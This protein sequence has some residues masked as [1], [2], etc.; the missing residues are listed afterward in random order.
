MDFLAIDRAQKNVGD[1]KKMI[2]QRFSL[3]EWLSSSFGDKKYD[4]RDHG[5]SYGK[6]DHDPDPPDGTS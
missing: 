5:G 2:L 3:R 1:I 6:R 4:Q